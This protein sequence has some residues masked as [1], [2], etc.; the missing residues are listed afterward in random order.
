MQ[1]EHIRRLGGYLRHHQ[2]KPEEKSDKLPED[3][4]RP[5]VQYMIDNHRRVADQFPTL[6][7]LTLAEAKAIAE[8]VK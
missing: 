2:S 3:T 7:T 8:K 1:D 4:I 6:T 5:E